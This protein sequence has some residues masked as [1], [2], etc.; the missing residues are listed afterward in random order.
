MI[1]LSR[2]SVLIQQLKLVNNVAKNLTPDS[3][4][5]HLL[6]EQVAENVMQLTVNTGTC[7]LSRRI[8]AVGVI[9]TRFLASSKDLERFCSKFPATK[10]LRLSQRRGNLCI[11]ALEEQEVGDPIISDSLTIKLYRGDISDFQPPAKPAGEVFKLNPQAAKLAFQTLANFGGYE[12]DKQPRAVVFVINQDTLHLYANKQ[13][14]S[15]FYLRLSLPLAEPTS[16]T[17]T[18]AIGGKN[19][20]YLTDLSTS[21]LISFTVQD[22]LFVEGDSG[23]SQ[24]PLFDLDLASNVTLAIKLCHPNENLI[25]CGERDISLGRL[26]EAVTTQEVDPKETSWREVKIEAQGD[27]LL[28]SK[29]HDL[30]RNE[31]SR[32]PTVTTSCLS[33]NWKVLSFNTEWFK[34]GLQALKSCL[35]ATGKDYIRIQLEYAQLEDSQRWRVLIEPL[36]SDCT[37]KPLLAVVCQTVEELDYLNEI[38]S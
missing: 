22:S 20:K 14:G 29:T 25:Y 28:V 17:G 26:I 10:K 7:W 5:T 30:D 36:G 13:N 33:S 12:S 15:N 3:V 19:L 31:F 21:E 24:I 9:G 4:Y 23:Y 6:L 8:L 27:C 1:Y 38:E 34:A 16:F 11:E 35:K 37:V 32:V 2:A 18:I